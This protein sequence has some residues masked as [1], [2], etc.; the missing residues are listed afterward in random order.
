MK[1]KASIQSAPASKEVIA[2]R[3]SR[4]AKYHGLVKG[5]A[6]EIKLLAFL[7]GLELKCLRDDLGITSGSRT[8]IATS[9]TVSEVLQGRSWD[10]YIEEEC[11][12]TAR[13]ARNYITAYENVCLKVPKL[14]DKLIAGC[15]SSLTSTTAGIMPVTAE[16]V[17]FLIPDPKALE[18]FCEVADEW[19]LHE[20]Y[21][22]PI[23]RAKVEENARQSAAAAAKRKGQAVFD[24]WFDD[25]AQAAEQKN[26]LRLPRNHQ[27]QLLQ[28][29]E[30]V[31]ADLRK[32]I[33]TAP[34]K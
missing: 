17:E 24:F 28:K 1:N 23:K 15:K 14:A 13:T 18:E 31:V 6:A 29:L 21:E 9:E 3:V 22:R 4:L 10:D 26:Y 27:Q 30:I 8:D 7:V 11:G 12:F 16:R 34:R 5:R 32:T 2:A 25:F 19:S 20:L 33:K